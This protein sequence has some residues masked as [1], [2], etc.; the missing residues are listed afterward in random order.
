MKRVLKDGVGACLVANEGDDIPGRAN[1]MVPATPYG[2]FVQMIKRCYF[3]RTFDVH[4]PE[5]IGINL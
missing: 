2:T 4:L 1:S 3:L 5:S